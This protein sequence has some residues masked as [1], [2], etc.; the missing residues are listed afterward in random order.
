MATEKNTINMKCC[1]F[2]SLQNA[3][4]PTNIHFHFVVSVTCFVVNISIGCCIFAN[5]REVIRCRRSFGRWCYLWSK[6]DQQNDLNSV[7]PIYFIGSKM[8]DRERESERVWT[9]EETKAKSLREQFQCT[10]SY[11]QILSKIGYEKYF[12]HRWSKARDFHLL[13]VVHLEFANERPTSKKIT[14]VSLITIKTAQAATAT[15]KQDEHVR[16]SAQI[17]RK[18][19]IEKIKREKIVN[20][21]ETYTRLCVAAKKNP[22]AEC[23]R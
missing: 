9:R 11:K 1:P 8:C 12:A 15:N 17:R 21:K 20:E 4:R 13:I 19:A 18:A 22:D 3:C 16:S 10:R 14:E 23:E 7:K 6:H 2:N 5:V